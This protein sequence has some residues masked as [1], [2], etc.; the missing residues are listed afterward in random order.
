MELELG[1][2]FLDGPS[3]TAILSSVLKAPK[4][5]AG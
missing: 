4:V 2:P 1:T 5:V 3:W